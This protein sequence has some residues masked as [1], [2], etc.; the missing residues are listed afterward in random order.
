MMIGAHSLLQSSEFVIWYNSGKI[1]IAHATMKTKNKKKYKTSRKLQ[2]KII[3]EFV[4]ILSMQ[5]LH[6]GKK[7][8]L[9]IK[10]FGLKR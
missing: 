9:L 2:K 5:K 6:F 3:S 10:F 8:K 1:I 4:L 7:Y